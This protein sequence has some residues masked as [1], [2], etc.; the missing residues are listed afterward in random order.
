MAATTADL[1]HKITVT[2]ESGGVKPEFTHDDGALIVAR[3]N[4]HSIE[5]YHVT[6]DSAG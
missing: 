6:D 3:D 4:P 5:K 2:C 1:A